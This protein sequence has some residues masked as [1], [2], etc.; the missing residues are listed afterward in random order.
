V[1]PK[2]EGYKQVDETIADEWARDPNS[3]LQVNWLD[4]PTDLSRYSGGDLGSM[5]KKPARS[6]LTRHIDITSNQNSFAPNQY[7]LTME[8]GE[9]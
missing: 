7:Q 6:F 2:Y 8:V 9:Q 3:K 1:L 4:H 5:Q